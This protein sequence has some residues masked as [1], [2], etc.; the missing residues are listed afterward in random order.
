M[1]ILIATGIYPPQIGGPSQY[2]KNL[3]EAFEQQKHQVKVRTYGI[4]AYL[5]TG[6]RHLLFFTKLLFVAPFVDV[7]IIL[8]TFS[9][10]LPT[11]LACKI[12]GQKAVIRTGGDFLWEQYVERTKRKVLFKN[13]YQTELS[14]LSFKERM[15]FKLTKWTLQNAGKVVFSTDWQRQV[16]NNAY[17]LDENN[18][19]IIE[20]YC[21]P[22]K[23]DADF[24]SKTFISSTRKLIWKNI[25][26]LKKSFLSAKEQYPEIELFEDNLP[27]SKFIEKLSKSYAVILV[28]L[29]DISPN[30]IF[31]AIRYNRPFICTR[32][33]GTYD[34]IKDAGIFVDPLNEAEIRAAILELS[35]KDGYEKAKEKVLNFNFVHTWL[36]I[37]ESFLA[38]MPRGAQASLWSRA[39]FVRYFVCGVTAAALNVFTLYVFTDVLKV[40]YLYSSIIAF[41][42]SVLVSFYLQ[43]FVVFRDRNLSGMHHQFSRFFAAVVLG[44][45][46]NTVIMYV[47]VDMIGLWY[48]L[49]QLIAGFFVMIQNFL[50]YKL[51][52]FNK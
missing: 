28:S 32:E 6:F 7:V 39:R 10:A 43:K 33:V 52:I 24:E 25:D 16:F 4:E 37:A 27:Y 49:S 31:D 42:T 9:V 18:T 30:M 44:V 19:T 34:R 50:F 29:G 14:N 26:V 13:F 11:V 35:T 5:P 21:G 38:L 20:N 46:T 23:G 48:I 41:F 15:I 1:K 17:G 40:W 22:K 51:F 45:I 3:K 8:D 47:C 2:A 12:F 36:E